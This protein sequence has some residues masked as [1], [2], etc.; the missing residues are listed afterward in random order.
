MRPKKGK[1]KG[2]LIM[3]LNAGVL[4]FLVYQEKAM[5]DAKTLRCLF[6]F[7]FFEEGKIR[8]MILSLLI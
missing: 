1:R 8:Y 5:T 6:L 2:V 7:F 4:I 3:G